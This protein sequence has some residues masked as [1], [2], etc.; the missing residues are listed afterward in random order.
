M[1]NQLVILLI[2]VSSLLATNAD[3]QCNDL[4]QQCNQF[5]TKC[6]LTTKSCCHL[7]D[8]PLSKAPSGVYQITSNCS[9]GSP[10]T[11]AVDVYCDMD[12]SDGGWMVIQRNVKDGVSFFESKKWIEYE[13]GFG[14]LKSSKFW[15]GL[16]ALH[17]FTQ[18]GDWELRIDFQF[19]N[20][21]WSHLH[22]NTFSVGS[23]SNEYP[24]TIGGFTGIAPEDPFVADPLNGRRF[25]AVDND[26][27]EYRGNCAALLGGWWYN[28][29]DHIRPND[30]P[31][32]IYLNSKW[33]AMLSIETKKHPRDCII[34]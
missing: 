32:E 10:F 5:K 3:Q 21:I 12:T 6:T 7:A 4:L 28:N 23:E 1:K 16:K 26:N 25:S 18:T 19:D 34:Q 8:L 33:Y 30:Q 14:D 24:L 9:C 17:C 22:Y 11:A 20:K 2:L 27:D 15:Y 13:E 29:C 31:L